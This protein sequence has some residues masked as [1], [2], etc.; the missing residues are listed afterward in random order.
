MGPRHSRC[1][2]IGKG[3]TSRR[4]Y[5][6]RGRWYDFWTNERLDGGREID[7]AVDLETLPLFVR[8]GAIVPFGPVKQYVDEKVE[9]LLSITVYPG[10]D[11]EFLLYED[12]GIS[13][14]YRKGDW[15][16]LPLKWNEARRALAIRLAP[17]SCMR[18]PRRRNLE[19]KVG[20][21]SQSVE[22]DGKPLE[23]R[24]S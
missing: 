6:P 12:D 19:V 8:E 17:G 24:F 1:T 23:V 18:S 14:N 13:F 20:D 5:L 4:L 21:S 7:R 11:G 16:G 2:V 3:A 9:G 15:M 10:A 22:F